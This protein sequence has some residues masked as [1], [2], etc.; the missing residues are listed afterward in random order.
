MS[1]VG[2]FV[3]NHLHDTPAVM[4]LKNP[5]PLVVHDRADPFAVGATF[6][7]VVLSFAFLGRG[8]TSQVI[9]SFA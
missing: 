4:A 2:R 1:Q 9:I 7:S 5:V 6:L 8:I 3:V